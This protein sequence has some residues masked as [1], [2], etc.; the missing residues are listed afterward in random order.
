[1]AAPEKSEVLA[2]PRRWP[3]Y[4]VTPSDLSRLRS[5]FSRSP[6]RTDTE[7]PQPSE[8][9]APASVAPSFFACS[10]AR[11]TSCSKVSRLY[12]KPLSARE[13]AWFMAGAMILAATCAAGPRHR[14]PI[15]VTQTQKRLFRARPV[16]C[17]RQRAGPAA[18][19]RNEA[20][21]GQQQDR[22]QAGEHGV[23]E[24]G[25]T[26]DRA[27]QGPLRSPA[28]ARETGGRARRSRSHHQFRRQA[29]PDA[30]RRQAHARPGRG[31]T[32]GR[33]RRPR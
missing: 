1:M 17:R 31:A 5:T 11:S 19:G 7:R 4:T 21:P 14:F 26:T 6:L 3:T 30:V 15:H 24:T 2:L 23:A 29:A 20:L 8:A 18:E 13:D 22:A 28:A 33:P 12:E 27:A 9:S 10:S 16:C 32:G 25:R